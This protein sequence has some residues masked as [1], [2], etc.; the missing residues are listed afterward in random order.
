MP[1]Q[2][3]L[4][5]GILLVGKGIYFFPHLVLALKLLAQNFYPKKFKSFEFIKIVNPLTGEEL[6][7]EEKIKVLENFRSLCQTLVRDA[8][9]IYCEEDTVYA[10][11]CNTGID[12]NVVLDDGSQAQYIIDDN[13]KADISGN[14]FDAGFTAVLWDGDEPIA[15]FE[16]SKTGCGV[17]H[18]TADGDNE[19]TVIKFKWK[20]IEKENV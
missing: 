13:V 1:E 4:K 9:E 14:I 16:M 2:G 10:F 7:D 11:N 12:I 17:R 18:S 15:T 8:S 5:V 19:K 20:K 6:T 3:H